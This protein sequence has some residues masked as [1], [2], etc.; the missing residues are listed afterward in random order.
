[1]SKFSTYSFGHYLK[2]YTRYV[3]IMSVMVISVG[4]IYTKLDPYKPEPVIS[5]EAATAG[6]K[7]VEAAR[8][9][10]FETEIEVSETIGADPNDPKS[11]NGLIT[12]GRGAFDVDSADGPAFNLQLGVGEVSRERVE[13]SR[14]GDDERESTDPDARP[15]ELDAKSLS[16][17]FGSTAKL[18]KD[19]NSEADGELLVSKFMLTPDDVNMRDVLYDLLMVSPSGREVLLGKDRDLVVPALEVHIYTNA[20]KTIKQVTY[21]YEKGNTTDFGFS[22]DIRPRA[23]NEPVKVKR[24]DGQYRR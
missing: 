3:A 16:E 12:Q 14:H 9:G 2:G 6:L 17:L 5:I 24:A 11:W 15:G 1:M 8:S 7:Q 23:L 20:D 4:Y 22:I 19:D 10:E 13:I 18:V 21:F